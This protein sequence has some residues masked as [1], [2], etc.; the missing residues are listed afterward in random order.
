[1]RR[2]IILLATVNLLSANENGNVSTIADA[3]K[4]GE[5]KG[6]VRYGMQDRDSNYHILQ[7]SPSDTSKNKIQAYS[8]LGGYIGFE[9]APLYNISIGTTIYTSNPIGSNPSDEKG[10]G[11]LYEVDGEQDSYSVVG[12]AFIKIKNDAHLL[13]V[14]RQELADYRFVSLSDVRMTPVTNEGAIYENSL[15]DNLKINLAYLTGQKARNDTEFKG[16][17][18]SARVS[19]GCGGVDSLGECI[20]S[21]S[22]KV[23]RGNYNPNNYDNNGNYI[24]ESKD[25]PLVG[26]LYNRDNYNIEIWNYYV[27]DFVNTLYLYGEYSINTNDDWRLSL[28]GQYSN[29]TDVGDGVAGNIDSSFYGIKISSDYK[30]AISMF[31]AYNEV[32]YNEES[33]DGGSIFTQWGTPQLFNS[34]QIQDGNLAG[35]KS[36]GAGIQFDFGALDILDNTVIRFRHAQYDMPDELYM[37]D[38]RQDRTES[39]FDLRYSFTK[40]SGFGIFTKLDGLS[41]QFRVAYNDFDTDYDLE[42]YKRIHNYNVFSVTDDFVDVRLTIDYIF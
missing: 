4:Y 31:I 8:A 25:M 13:K 12:E 35:T 17:V 39:T 32:D 42:E 11:G 18:R 27:D 6:L 40:K 23:L 9:T 3:F 29:Q 38:A 1:M 21:G 41:L 7:D 30:D 10:L 2:Y 36:I 5:V 33:Y 16:M 24:G 20:E 14:G 28:A 19:T 37:I 26:L 15:I 34:F 22:K